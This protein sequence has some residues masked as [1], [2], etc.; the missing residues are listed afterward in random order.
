MATLLESGG[1]VELWGGWA[2]TLPPA[3][4]EANGDGS[5]SA[6][7][8]DWTVDVIIV[9]VAGHENGQPVSPEE[10]LGKERAVKVSGNGWVGGV[11]FLHETDNARDVYRLAANLAAINT[12]MSF[13]VSYFEKHQQ[14]FAENLMLKVA[15]SS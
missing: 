2:V 13:W 5:W 12:S 14:P 9:E 3:H 15:H 6:W 1:T 7:G 11:E 8:V 10:M 4:Y